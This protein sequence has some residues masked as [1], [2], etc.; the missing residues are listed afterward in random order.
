MKTKGIVLMSIGIA[1]ALLVSVYD[2]LMGR[3]RISYGPYSLIAWV[4]CAVLIISGVMWT[5]KK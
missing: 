2:L 5:F 3:G 4:I 1:G